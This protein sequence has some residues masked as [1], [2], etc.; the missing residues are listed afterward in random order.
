MLAGGGR[1]GLSRLAG[2]R[3]I[4]LRVRACAAR[5]RAIIFKEIRLPRAILGAL[6][7]GAL[8]LSGAA[9]QGYLRNPL[10]EPSLVGVSGGAALGAVLAIHLGLAAVFAFA[11][12]L[13]GLAGAAVA[14][15]AVVALAGV[16]GGPVTLILAGL[17]VSAIATALISLALNLSQNPFAAV[18]MVLWMMGSLTDR[19]LTQVW[20]A[21][22]LMLLGMALL[23][24]VGR[25]LD[26]LTL[27]EDAAASL[28]I[29]L[30]RTR[31]A[32]VAGTALSVGAAT[33][34]TGIIGFVGLLVPHVLRPFAGHRPA[35][36]AARE[37]ARRRHDAAAGRRCPAPDPAVGRA[38]DRRA[39]GADRRA[40]LRLAG[41]QDARGAGAVRVEARNLHVRLKAR[42]VLIG[43][44]F[45]AH[46]GQLTA[47]IGPNG[48]GKTT[49]LRALAG[50]LAPAA[51]AASL[52][53]R[54]VA[55]WRPREL[56]RALAY[57]PQERIVHWAMTARAV[58]ALGRLPYRPMGAGESAADARAID[59]ALAAMD[60]A[61][62]QG[63][64]VL[65]ISGGERA[66][67]LVARAL[68]QEPRVL[69]ADEPAAGLDPAH[70]LTL[71]AHLSALAAAGRTVVV[72]L[73]DLS[74]A[75]RFCHRIVLMQAGR[76]VAA[77]SPEDVLTGEHL[78]AAYGI[79]ARYVQVDG[80]PVV[81][82]LEVLP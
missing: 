3:S 30:A 24:G 75:A 35:L 67:V 63:R 8:G 78:A 71:F 64:P 72:A 59:A 32:V 80:V 77:G 11:L 50:L 47:V 57:L 61:H 21:A 23:L 52:D 55:E 65:E 81:L 53:G 9:L 48:A 16:H 18:E 37:H 73:H 70:Q 38:Q 62:L 12:P 27:G 68:A 69:L 51:G 28:G 4:G 14:M 42:E 34:V 66:R 2:D 15:L 19:S 56:A 74:L 58:V 20:L 79:K 82:P 6:V 39:H 29:D 76:L 41:A 36:L 33:A 13:G 5:L 49:L 60:V 43:L 46:A 40:V 17:A 10:A 44:D 54:A 7:G 22:P 45:S 26:A 1:R 25:A 31:L